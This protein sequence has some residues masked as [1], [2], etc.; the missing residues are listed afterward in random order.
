MVVVVVGTGMNVALMIDSWI[1]VAEAGGEGDLITEEMG[2]VVR[3][4]VIAVVLIGF[5]RGAVVVAVAG[6]GVTAGAVAG[7]EAVAV[8][9]ATVA[10]L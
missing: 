6:A 10:A 3:E 8:A 7:Q 4:E 5:E 2:T 1:P 9:A